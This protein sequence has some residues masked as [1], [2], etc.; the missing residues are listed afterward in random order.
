MSIDIISSGKC[1][2]KITKIVIGKKPCPKI[3]PINP[4]P[5]PGVNAFSYGA[6]DQLVN[7]SIIVFFPIPIISSPNISNAG[8][9]TVFN[10]PNTG[11]Y[12][13]E[14]NLL[15]A[16]SNQNPGPLVTITTSIERVLAGSDMIQTIKSEQQ[17]LAVSGPGIITY[18]NVMTTAN[19][20][21]SDQIRIRSTAMSQAEP[22]LIDIDSNDQSRPSNFSGSLL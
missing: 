4:I 13:L 12:Q 7:D 20:N 8:N 10:V 18:Q 1:K 19:L 22:V 2:P 14:T 16:V 5:F 9:Q 21:Q 17:D 15:Y 6:E 11:Q 3:C